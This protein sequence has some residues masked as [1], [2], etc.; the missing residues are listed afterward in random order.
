MRDK[1]LEGRLRNMDLPNN[2]FKVTKVIKNENDQQE[3]EIDI[4]NRSAYF[5][6]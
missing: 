2:I 6:I 4:T 1:Y 3:Q 5:K